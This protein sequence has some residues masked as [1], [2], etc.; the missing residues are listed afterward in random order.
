MYSSVVSVQAIQEVFTA[1]EWVKDA[2]NEARVEANLLA[3]TSK[4]LGTTE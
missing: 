3:E 2:G 1:E 4:A